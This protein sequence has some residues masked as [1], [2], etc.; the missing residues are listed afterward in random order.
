MNKR[1][2]LLPFVLYSSGLA[3]A[4]VVSDAMNLKS[5]YYGSFEIDNGNPAKVV[6]E[7]LLPNQHI[8]LKLNSSPLN[9]AFFKALGAH[10]LLSGRR[11]SG[12]RATCENPEVQPTNF[13]QLTVRLNGCNIS[14]ALVNLCA[15][16]GSG[17]SLVNSNASGESAH[18]GEGATMTAFLN[19]NEI[20]AASL[21]SNSSCN[22]LRD[23]AVLVLPDQKYAFEFSETSTS[24]G[25]GGKL[26]YDIV[27]RNKSFSSIR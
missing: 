20:S 5:E 3:K 23:G 21:P 6:I 1:I 11:C 8:E 7:I 12:L 25:I 9:T 16:V 13:S 14:A 22:K 2:F 17:C 26:T 4:D 15:E 10:S 24:P 18:L 19:L 27:V